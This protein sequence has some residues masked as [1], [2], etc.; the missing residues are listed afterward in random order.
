MKPEQKVFLPHQLKTIEIDAENRTFKVNGEEIGN[1]CTGF[2][3]TCDANVIVLDAR[4]KYASYRIGGDN[5]DR[6]K[7]E[8][9]GDDRKKI[10]ECIDR[11]H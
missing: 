6:S 2:T 8:G 5:N 4:V 11:L 7:A 3:I 9:R 1:V 10:T